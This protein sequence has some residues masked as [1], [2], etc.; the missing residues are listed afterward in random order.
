MSYNNRVLA[1]DDNPTNLAIIEEL[2]GNRY[3]LQLAH[4]GKEAMWCA[5]KLPPDVLLLD[6]MMP[7]PNGYEVCS[8]FRSDVRLRNCRVIL[9]SALTNIDDRLRGFRAGADDF[10][11][12]PFDERE[13]IAKVEASMKARKMFGRIEQ[14]VANL[15]DVTGHALE[16]MTHLRDTETGEHLD[17]VRDLSLMVANAMRN[18]PYAEQIDEQFLDNLYYSS[19]LHDIGKIAISDAILQ[20]PA[21]LTDAEFTQMKRHTVMGERILKLYAEHSS[22]S[23]FPMAAEIARWHHERFDG[24]GYPDGIVGEAIP[25]AARIVKVVDVFDALV[26]ERVYKDCYTPTHARQIIAD[27]AG[28]AYDPNVVEAMLQCF[29]EVLEVYELEA[30]HC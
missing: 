20:K 11:T 19:A 27:G 1:V 22:E 9:V 25:L 28:T 3:N 15:Y 18:G 16:L 8:Q 6:V 12:K 5:Q 29:D 2:L 17:R 14:D 26:S 24:K 21:Q 23:F 10:V 4:D 13:L 7:R 30:A